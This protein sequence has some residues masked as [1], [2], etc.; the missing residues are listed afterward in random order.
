[1]NEREKLT[2]KVFGLN[3]AINLIDGAYYRFS[4]KLG[5]NENTMALLY[6]LSDNRPHTQKEISKEWFIPKTTINT[7]IK[8]MDKKGYITLSRGSHTKEKY[9]SLTQSGEE[10]SKNRLKDLKERERAALEKTL[11]KYP[12]EFIEAFRY[13]ARQLC[14]EFDKEIKEDGTIE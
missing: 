4:R 8:D 12:E 14:R 6:A 11:E 13:F 2:G 1:M 7:I 10:Y 3:N 5:L 9:I